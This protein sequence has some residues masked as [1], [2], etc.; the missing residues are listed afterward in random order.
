MQ[1]TH[2]CNGEGLPD[3]PSEVPVTPVNVWMHDSGM[4]CQHDYS[5]PV[6]RTEHA[7]MQLH[8]GVMQPCWVCQTRGFILVRRE[9][10]PNETVLRK[11]LRFITRGN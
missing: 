9:P 7:V 10:L 11:V 2:E 5:C 6:C 8:T 1:T 3:F 4:V